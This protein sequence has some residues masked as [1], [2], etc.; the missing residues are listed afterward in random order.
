[1]FERS[2][3]AC[4]NAVAAAQKAALPITAVD[5]W[6]WDV[7]MRAPYRSA[8]RLTTTAHNVLVR[9]GLQNGATGF[10]ESAPATYVT[11]E[12]QHTVLAA[13]QTLGAAI[14]GQS[15]SDA[16]T[17]L[18]EHVF[19]SPGAAGALEIAL[20]DAR[21][22][23]AGLPLFRFLGAASNESPERATDLSLPL[24]PPNEARRQAE[25]AAWQGFRVLKIKVGGPDPAEDAAR[26]RAVAAGAPAAQLRLDGNQGFDTGEAAVRFLDS[27]APD[28]AGRIALFEQP[29]PAGSDAALA[30]VAARAFCPVYADEAVKTPGD[31]RRLVASGACAGVVLKLAKSGLSGTEAIARATFAAG[32][33]CLLGCMME[34]RIGIGAALHLALALGETIVP[35]FDLDGHL[36][37]NDTARVAGSGL[38][39]SDDVLR[40]DANAPGLGLVAETFSHA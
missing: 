30:F 25:Q 17:Q 39:Q 4:D 36:L 2:P 1:M 35:D 18:A 10:G 16:A 24:L 38:Y 21:A 12:T 27:L 34:T 23:A 20:A 32:E 3:N 9:V 26:V 22:R 7:P 6:A 14:M 19:A 11:G 29:T 15:A 40:A 33:R 8:Q 13:A 37:V 28:L 5:V 31:A